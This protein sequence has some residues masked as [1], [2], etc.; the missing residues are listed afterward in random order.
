MLKFLLG[1]IILAVILWKV[2][3]FTKKQ[4]LPQD[5]TK[6]KSDISEINLQIE[7]F[8]GVPEYFGYKSSW[9]AIKADKNR[10]IAE[11][12]KHSE[13]NSSHKLIF[14]YPSWSV[15]LT[16]PK[17][18]WIFIAGDSPVGD[19]KE[20]LADL[21]LLLTKLSSQ[22]GEV[23]FFATHRIVEYHC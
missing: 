14:K 11:F 23:Q 20:S 5:A 19:S 6:G 18:G 4:S 3:S 1:A 22:F 7:D 13:E 15:F 9:L 2:N 12:I 8:K 21:K 16:S 17:N 10:E